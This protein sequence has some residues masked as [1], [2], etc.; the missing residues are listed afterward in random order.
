MTQLFPPTGA[1]HGGQLAAG[2]RRLGLLFVKPGPLRVGPG[3]NSV[4]AGA[5]RSVE[6]GECAW[7]AQA[8]ESLTLTPHFSASFPNSAP[9]LSRP[10]VRWQAGQALHHPEG[11]PWVWVLGRHNKACFRQQENDMKKMI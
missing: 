2:P 8:L 1:Q 5:A 4:T 3:G 10:L 7:H 9:N 11:N 6:A